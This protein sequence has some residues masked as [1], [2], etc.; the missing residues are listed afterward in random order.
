M[1]TLW[2]FL[3]T[4]WKSIHP[5]VI[6]NP[7]E[8]AIRV[9]FGKHSRRIEPGIHW[10]LPMFDSFFVQS[11]RRRVSS[12]DTQTAQSKDGYMVIAGG[13]LAYEI[14]DINTLY[15][16]LHH[17]EDTLIRDAMIAI[18][19]EIRARDQGDC[20]A[21]AIE[22]GAIGRLDFNRYGVQLLE[23]YLTDFAFAR[24][25]R[26]INAPRYSNSGDTLSTSQQHL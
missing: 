3:A 26:L 12:L 20:S 9:R 14:T 19:R 6:I 2:D 18:A 24:T 11:I 5:W 17:P 4:F 13:C 16:T 7:W 22:R 10:K 21:D 15:Q 25:Y 23:L 8:Q 1:K